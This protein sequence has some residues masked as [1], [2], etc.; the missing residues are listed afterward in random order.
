[1][2]LIDFKDKD[3]WGGLLPDTFGVRNAILVK[4]YSRDSFEN[5]S[6]FVDY[7]Y[8][9]VQPAQSPKWNSGFICSSKRKLSDY[10]FLGYD[11]YQMQ[12]LRKDKLYY[13]DYIL[14][15]S[16]SSFIWI[17]YTSTENTHDINQVKMFE[18]LRGFRLIKS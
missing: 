1:M 18:F 9:H 15:E 10:K 6:A 7:V 5:L 17:D 4:S 11:A 3:V 14:L 13:C 2:E 16:K 8:G 12:L